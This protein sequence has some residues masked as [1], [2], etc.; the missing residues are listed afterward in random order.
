MRVV[1]SPQIVACADKIM[2]ATLD[3]YYAPNKTIRELNDLMKGG[4]GP[5]LDLLKEFSGVVREELGT[6]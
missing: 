4:G 2:S 3:T 5:G 1:S 6:L